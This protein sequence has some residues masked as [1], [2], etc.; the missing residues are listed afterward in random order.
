M[1]Q[2]Q[3]LSPEN[4]LSPIRNP[5]DSLHQ[6]LTASLTPHSLHHLTATLSAP[7]RRGRTP[8]SRRIPRLLTSPSLIPHPPPLTHAASQSLVKDHHAESQSR[9]AHQATT[10]QSRT[11]P[12]PTTTPF[13]SPPLFCPHRPCSHCR[14]ASSDKVCPSPRFGDDEDYPEQTE[15]EKDNSQQ[16]GKDIRNFV[17]KGK[18]AQVQSTINQMMK[19]DLTEQCDQQCAI[20]FYTSAIPFNVI[21]NPEFLKFCEMVERYGIGYK[22]PFLP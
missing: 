17:T 4:G 18:G 21:K 16:K 6:T 10:T 20:F 14:S 11:A 7:P 9:R 3:P 5:S 1:L 13:A 2:P 12:E 15:K 22:P 8:E 19:K